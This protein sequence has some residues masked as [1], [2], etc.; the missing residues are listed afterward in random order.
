NY[1]KKEFL[2]AGIPDK[3]LMTIHA[4]KGLEFESVFVDLISGWNEDVNSISQDILEEERRILYVALS[5]AKNHLVLL[6]AYSIKKKKRLED[7][8]LSY[9]LQGRIKISKTID[10]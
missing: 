5:R 8:F 9:F 10:L 1:R 7:I 4:S 6:G 3:H 2:L